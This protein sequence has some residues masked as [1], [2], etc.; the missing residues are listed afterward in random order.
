MIQ[1]SAPSTGSTSPMRRTVAASGAS[2]QDCGEPI[3]PRKE[4]SGEHGAQDQ[5]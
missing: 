3:V 1:A 2:A 4:R 5:R